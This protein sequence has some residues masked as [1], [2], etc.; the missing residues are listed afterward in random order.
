MNSAYLKSH[1]FGQFQFQI[2]AIAKPLEIDAWNQVQIIPWCLSFC[3]EKVPGEYIYPVRR[4]PY[5]LFW[6]SEIWNSPQ[7]LILVSSRYL[8]SQSKFVPFLPAIAHPIRKVDSWSLLHTLSPSLRAFKKYHGPSKY[9]DG[10]V[11]KEN[12][13]AILLNLKRE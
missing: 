12:N 5:G 11:F 6:Q 1:F 13:P 7:M 2:F 3:R 4:K 8:C 10:F 9:G